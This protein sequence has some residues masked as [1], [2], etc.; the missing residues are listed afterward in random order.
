MHLGVSLALV[1]LGRA[2]RC[3]QLGV[4]HGARLEH[5]TAINQFGVDGGQNRLAQPVR[6][7]HVAKPQ[8]GA[9]VGQTADLGECQ[10]NQRQQF[11]PWDHQVHLIKEFPLASALADQLESGMG[12]T[13][14]LH[15]C[16]VSDAVAEALMAGTAFSGTDIY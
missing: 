5:Q 1:A 9:L 13:Y 11:R 8:D 4:H 3:N 2:G 15:R 10:C 12:E 14:L 7:E 16:T 6:F